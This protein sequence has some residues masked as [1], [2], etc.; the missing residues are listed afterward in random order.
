MKIIKVKIEGKECELRESS[1]NSLKNLI[2]SGHL[3]KNKGGY[4]WNEERL[5]S[6]KRYIKKV[7][8]GGRCLRNPF[9]RFFFGSFIVRLKICLVFRYLR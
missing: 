9:Y 4:V 7:K 6:L 8:H 5:K 3:E 1:V 2:E